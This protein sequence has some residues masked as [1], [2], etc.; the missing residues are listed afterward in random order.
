MNFAKK[1][2]FWLIML[3]VI[4]GGLYL[5]DRR[6]EDVKVERE[7][8]LRLFSF[9]PEEVQAFT[10][11]RGGQAI[12]LERRDDKWWVLEPVVDRGDKQTIE[13]FLDTVVN[14]RKDAVL[15]EQAPPEKLEELGLASP[16]ITVIFKTMRGETIIKF[17]RKGPTHNISYAML[18]GD[19]RIYRIHSDVGKEADK[20][21]YELRDKTI[22]AFEP[23]KTKRLELYR[24][25]RKTVV[26]TQPLGGKWD[27][28]KPIR[29]R[30]DI[31]KVLETLYRIKESDIKWFIDEPTEGE[32]YGLDDPLVRLFIEDDKGRYGFIVGKKNRKVRGYFAKRADEQRVFV[33]EEDLVHHLLQPAERWS[34][35]DERI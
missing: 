25:G 11:V 19:P 24:K 14:A 12:R 18:E 17:G 30:A 32:D 28:L 26:I 2:I 15:F 33:I 1:T 3:V 22:I 9:L 21:L 20:G 29:A 7:R 35:E 16:Y 10:V 31:E 4:G 27:M 5:L 23:L 8:A 6:A 34:A 13:S